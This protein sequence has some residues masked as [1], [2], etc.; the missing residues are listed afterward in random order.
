MEKNLENIILEMKRLMSYDRSLGNLVIE[1]GSA[2]I[3]DLRRS[4]EQLSN[5]STSKVAVDKEGITY[6]QKFKTYKGYFDNEMMLGECFYVE[7]FTSSNANAYSAM[8]IPKDKIFKDNDGY[9]IKADTKDY[10][11]NRKIK[12]YLPKD[13]F[14]KQFIGMVKSFIAYET[15]GDAKKRQ[16]GKKYS[17]IYQLTN[18]EDAIV[19]QI[20][21]SEGVKHTDTNVSRGWQISTFG[22]SE[23]GY[24][25]V[26]NQ[27]DVGSSTPNTLINSTLPSEFVE[28]SLQNYGEEY[29]R[30]EFDIWYDSGW[31]T[32]VMIGGAVLL[33]VITGGVA[34]LFTAGMESALMARGI[35][36][37]TELGAELVVG[38]PEAIYL[39]KRGNNAGATMVL[40]FSLLPLL[41]KTG[42]IK[43]ASG[44][45]SNK[46]QYE[47]ISQIYRN[48]DQFKTPGDIK[49]W[50]KSL[51]NKTRTFVEETL[52]Q[53]STALKKINS[54]VL[55]K[56]I[57][58][59]LKTLIDE[60]KVNKVVTSEIKATNL[61]FTNLLKSY[62]NGKWSTPL[63][64][65]GLNLGA[66][67]ASI[68]IIT[69]LVEDDEELKRDPQKI[70]ERAADNAQKI[71]DKISQES[72]GE[73]NKKISELEAKLTSNPN[74]MDSAR[75]Y[76][77]IV[78]D[79]NNLNYQDLKSQIMRSFLQKVIV[80]IKTKYLENKSKK[81]YSENQK[82]IE[83]FNS[84]M[85]GGADEIWKSLLTDCTTTE[86]TPF[87]TRDEACKFLDWVNTNH[88]EFTYTWRNIKLVITPCST[89]DRKFQPDWYLINDCEIKYAY[90]KYKSI[91]NNGK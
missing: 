72:V 50:I 76:L 19:T 14:F 60:V 21:D 3:T 56:D 61:T 43:R 52:Q 12:V 66:V 83:E 62:S 65:I 85:L 74:D 4:K 86:N 80:D 69:T 7:E 16:G 42:F 45:L 1:Q 17:L 51:D 29:G 73:L 37:A 26:K 58:D 78:K 91:Y 90:S 79:L 22:G 71:Y 6:N 11:D 41:N 77:N 35:T 67:F 87:K 75:E 5:K 2:D 25:R 34:G 64:L 63:K 44:T 28:Y 15:C 54:D 31:G 32:V 68:P 55:E 48:S 13:E 49:A 9:Y 36:L 23:S 82:M 59:G 57:K 33:S 53:G 39:A 38:I 30:S 8:D 18:P 20:V 10:G 40:L 27:N 46:Q 70:L 81:Q 24:F 89:D 47:L 88:P 84:V